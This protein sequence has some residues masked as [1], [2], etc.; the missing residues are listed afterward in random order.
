M[1]D[2]KRNVILQTQQYNFNFETYLA[3]FHFLRPLFRGDEGIKQYFLDFNCRIGLFSV[4]IHTLSG[5][6]GMTEAASNSIRSVFFLTLQI[7][8]FVLRKVIAEFV[9]LM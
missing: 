6:N 8:V 9:H 5:N 4:C 1:I 2:G 3:Y 7:G